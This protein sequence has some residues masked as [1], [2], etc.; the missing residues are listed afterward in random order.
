MYSIKLDIN[1]EICNNFIKSLVFVKMNWAL[2]VDK[3][4]L[5]I[6]LLK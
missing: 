4:D 3:C 6:F 2:D 5:N 1:F